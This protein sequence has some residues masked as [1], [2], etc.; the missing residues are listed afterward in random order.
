M[1]ESHVKI[2]KNAVVHGDNSL[3]D[4]EVKKYQDDGYKKWAKDKQYGI[5]W[6]G[7]EGILS[8]VKRKFGEKTRSTRPENALHEAKLKFWCYARMRESYLRWLF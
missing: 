2:R 1:I 4:R 5:R 7:T 8:A 3:R 6:N